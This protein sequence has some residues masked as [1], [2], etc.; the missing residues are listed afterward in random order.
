MKEPF[1]LSAD[2]IDLKW[3]IEEGGIGL[4]AS[5]D[6]TG[7]AYIGPYSLNRSGDPISMPMSFRHDRLM[8]HL[9]AGYIHDQP[10]VVFIDAEVTALGLHVRYVPPV[11]IQA[12]GYDRFK[13]AAW[14]TEAPRYHMSIFP[15]NSNEPEPP[16][17]KIL[18]DPKKIQGH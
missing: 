5:T 9:V 18:S 1:P 7:T 14:G 12:R 16:D 15:A 11:L 6:P 17:F 2:D 10:I 8:C 4:T 3:R 13:F